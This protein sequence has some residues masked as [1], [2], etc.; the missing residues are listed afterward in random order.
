MFQIHSFRDDWKWFLPF[1]SGFSSRLKRVSTLNSSFVRR[2]QMIFTRWTLGQKIL[3]LGSSWPSFPPVSCVLL[4]N[5]LVNLASESQNPFTVRS[6]ANCE[7]GSLIHRLYSCDQQPATL[8]F[9]STWTKDKVLKLRHPSQSRMKAR[10]KD[11]ALLLERLSGLEPRHTLD[12]LH[13]MLV[14]HLHAGKG[15]QRTPVWF[16]GPVDTFVQ[17][18]MQLCEPSFAN[19][20]TTPP[21]RQTSA[22]FRPTQTGDARPLIS[23]AL[24]PSN[25][26]GTVFTLPFPSHTMNHCS[27]KTKENGDFED[28]SK[29]IVQACVQ[30]SNNQTFKFL[31]NVF[32][33][34]LAVTFLLW[35]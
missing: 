22:L 2:L 21:P 13:E 15:L 12:H 25:F 20:Q 33:W 3:L 35:S 30:W 6:W 34:N 27:M 14:V 5:F 28:T 17:A 31:G 32:L 26:S 29:Q 8:P 24:H 1:N 9:W 11:T 18:R 23:D 16:K 19:A 7:K 4:L 10:H